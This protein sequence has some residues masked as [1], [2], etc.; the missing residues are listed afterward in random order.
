MHAPA[1]ASLAFTLEVGV[2]TNNNY[3]RHRYGAPGDNLCPVVGM[4]LQYF[5]AGT[6][7]HRER[8]PGGKQNHG[9]WC[10]VVESSV[11]EGAAAAIPV[12]R[13]AG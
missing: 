12:D 2:A 7:Y 9:G 11:P 3:P 10:R 8:R 5:H 1:M 6:H 4:R 13:N